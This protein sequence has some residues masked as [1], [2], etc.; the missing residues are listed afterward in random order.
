MLAWKALRIFQ[1]WKD[2]LK[3]YLTRISVAHD[4]QGTY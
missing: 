1:C 2:G 3:L 4:V